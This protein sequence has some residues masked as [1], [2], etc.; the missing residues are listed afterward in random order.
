MPPELEGTD[1]EEP[2]TDVVEAEE[3]VEEP[4]TG[5][6]QVPPAAAK[7]AVPPPTPAAPNPD[8]TATSAPPAMPRPAPPPPTPGPAQETTGDVEEL[9]AD[10]LVT[11]NVPAAGV[12]ETALASAKT[13]LSDGAEK[14]RIGYYEAE[15]R[16]LAG[17]AHKGR[18]AL[19]HHEIGELLES[20]GDEGAAVKAYA[21]AL[22]ADATLK[23]N[24]WAI[25]RVFQQRALWPNLLKLLD[26]EIR[27]AKGEAERAELLVEK[28]QLLEDR[29]NEPQQARDCYLKA[30]EVYPAS[31]GAYMALEKI[32]AREG[33]VGGL[34]RTCR[35]LAN[36][37]AEPAR[38]DAR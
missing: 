17:D 10:D 16:A 4:V 25:R 36:A 33:D 35:G 24:L 22:Q 20:S 13:A 30:I 34:A 18:Q 1:P 23:P 21:K 6:G 15:L 31:I 26:A 11:D 29:L 14:R 38:T 8:I 9:S 2:T 5:V 12:L 3:L 19:Y 7:A 37:T 28:G 27:F 32:Y